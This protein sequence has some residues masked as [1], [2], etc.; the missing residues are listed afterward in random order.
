SIAT[1][2]PSRARTLAARRSARSV[3]VI[4]ELRPAVADPS[5]PLPLG[6]ALGD[7]GGDAFAPVAERHHGENAARDLFRGRAVC[8]VEPRAHSPVQL[9]RS[10]MVAR[11]LDPAERAILLPL[12]PDVAA[13]YLAA[14]ALDRQRRRDAG[15]GTEVH[16]EPAVV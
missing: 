1:S 5:A 11:H 16:G 15:V 14:V 8:R 13:L 6:E 7:A 2:G 3:D 9:L 10:G 12:L 4:E